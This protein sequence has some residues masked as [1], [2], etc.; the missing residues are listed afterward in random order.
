[1]L[2]EHITPTHKEL[3]KK[4][5][6]FH[7]ECDIDNPCRERK[8]V[9][10]RMTFAYIMKKRGYSLSSIGRMLVKNHATIIHY[11][12]NVEWYMKTDAEFRENFN[13][14]YQDTYLD[15]E[16]IHLLDTDALIKEVFSLRKENKSL[17]S[18][19][20]GLKKEQLESKRDRERFSSIFEMVRQRTHEG[21]EEQVLKKL[22]HMYNGLYS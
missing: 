15:D 2:N 5:V 20:E 21:S 3:L 6:N 11:L 13:N 1:M 12:K 18:L 8:Y 14:V 16:S 17:Y 9:N 7:F 4:A 10:A 19:V 22:N